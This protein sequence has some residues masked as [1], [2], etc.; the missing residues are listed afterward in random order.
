LSSY[1][2]HRTQE[3]YFLPAF[4]LFVITTLPL[5][6]V[7]RLCLTYSI[8][9]VAL[10]ATIAN[11]GPGRP[12]ARDY[13]PYTP[14]CTYLAISSYYTRYYFSKA[15]SRHQSRMPTD[16]NLCDSALFFSIAAGYRGTVT[17][18]SSPVFFSSC[19]ATAHLFDV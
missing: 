8:P 3:T 17:L 14:P 2:Q 9:P 11:I 15:S 4:Y 5:Y 12:C 13:R 10:Q 7:R 19:L 1:Y 16:P 6:H 18:T